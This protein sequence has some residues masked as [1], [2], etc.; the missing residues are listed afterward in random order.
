VRLAL[1]LALTVLCGLWGGGSGPAPA[2]AIHIAIAR[3]RGG[4]SKPRGGWAK[5]EPSPAEERRTAMAIPSV[6]V[7]PS[8]GADL[9]SLESLPCSNMVAHFQPALLFH[10]LCAFTAGDVFNRIRHKFLS[11][12]TSRRQEALTASSYG[13]IASAIVSLKSAPSPS[14]AAAAIRATPQDSSH[15]GVQAIMFHVGMGEGRG[16]ALEVLAVALEREG[17]GTY[18][19]GF[20]NYN[21]PML[22]RLAHGHWTRAIGDALECAESAQFVVISVRGGHPFHRHFRATYRICDHPS[23]SCKCTAP[24]YWGDCKSQGHAP[25]GR[26]AVGAKKWKSPIPQACQSIAGA[27]Q[28]R[29]EGKVS[30]EEAKRIMAGQIGGREASKGRRRHASLEPAPP[31]VPI[32][33]VCRCPPRQVPFKKRAPMSWVHIPKTGTT[34]ANTLYHYACP[35]IPADTSVD[36]LAA[37]AI[38]GKKHKGAGIM[39]NFL[40]TTYPPQQ[41]CEERLLIQADEN[42]GK[43]GSGHRAIGMRLPIDNPTYLDEVGNVATIF[44]DP[45]QR[46]LS[47]YYYG[48]HTDGMWGPERMPLL[49]YHEVPMEVEDPRAPPAQ[50]H[51]PKL[52]FANWPRVA[53]CQTRMVI[54]DACSGPTEIT[55]DLVV[56]AVRRIRSGWF[57]F[58]GLQDMWEQSVCLFHAMHGGEIKEAEVQKTR[59]TT[60]GKVQGRCRDAEKELPGFV[61]WADE[62]VF[63]AA[64]EWFIEQGEKYGCF[65]RQ[66]VDEALCPSQAAAL[67]GC[68]GADAANCAAVTSQDPLKPY[69]C[70]KP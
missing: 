8:Q 55:P 47:A 32:E 23:G 54:G 16:A 66:E 27:L 67:M 62:Y 20:N 36:D 28:S 60:K 21:N 45:S 52:I 9:T 22:L 59:T 15:G 4:G 49:K 58:I 68:A 29:W 50:R 14:E 51:N 25:R 64:K 40:L 35:R 6:A 26:G 56:E 38:L 70:A 17:L 43:K 24:H 37:K 48:L 34:F 2:G 19:V 13:G 5:E 39:A 30:K 61:D 12:E 53:G 69:T 65:V 57:S 42:F 63:A 18:L 7:T 44:R 10:N 46:L 11:D 33:E 41:Y 3:E 1:L 31:A